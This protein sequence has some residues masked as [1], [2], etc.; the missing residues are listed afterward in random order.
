MFQLFT[1]F[2]PVGSYL[3]RKISSPFIY[4]GS[5]AI[6]LSSTV[7]IS[8]YVKNFWAFIFTY[9]FISGILHGTQFV[10]P[11]LAAQLYFPKRKTLVSGIILTGRFTRHIVSA[12]GNQPM[13]QMRMQRLLYPIRMLTHAAQPP[14]SDFLPLSIPKSKKKKIFQVYIL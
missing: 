9:G 11:M 5:Y 14:P 8:S 3:L 13:C 12:Y 6:L 10:L 7:L 4:C 1:C 2:I